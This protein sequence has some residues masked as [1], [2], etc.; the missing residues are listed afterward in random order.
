L[1]LLRVG[2]T[3]ADRS[4]LRELKKR[5]RLFEQEVW[6]R[7]AAYLSEANRLFPVPGERSR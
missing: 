4:Y 2:L 5:D 3:D 6:R 7:A 1:G